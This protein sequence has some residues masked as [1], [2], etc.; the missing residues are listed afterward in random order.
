MLQ[1]KQKP[2]WKHIFKEITIFQL[3]GNFSKKGK[4]HS[5]GEKKVELEFQVSGLGL[6][7]T[8]LAYFKLSRDIL[9]LFE[10]TDFQCLT[11][12]KVKL[13]ILKIYEKTQKV[14]PIFLLN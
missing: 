5:G 10:G 4:K 9:W 2:I 1:N 11:L 12:F 7:T 8:T 6:H 3:A 14:F 13:H